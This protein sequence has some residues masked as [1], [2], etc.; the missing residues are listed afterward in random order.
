[1]NRFEARKVDNC[2]AKAS[3]FQY[4]FGERMTEE[5]LRRFPKTCELRIYRNFPKPSYA[6]G[7]SDGTR[8]IGAMDDTTLRA[9]FPLENSE[10]AKLAFESILNSLIPN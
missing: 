1:M 10:S 4:S 8:L 2:V 9:L 7:F 3:V 5:F 6:M